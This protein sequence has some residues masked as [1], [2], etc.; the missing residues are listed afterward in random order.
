MPNLKFKT[1]LYKNKSNLNNGDIGFAQFDETKTEGTIIVKYADEIFDLMPAPGT[2]ATK[3]KPLISTGENTSPEYK[4]LPIEGGGTGATTAP[5]AL[6]N[7]G[8]DIS[9]EELNSIPDEF[10]GRAL[11]TEGTFFVQGSGSSIDST[12]KIATWKGTSNRFSSYY[13]GLSILYKLDVAGSS[14]V[15]LDI[16]GLGAKTVYLVNTTKLTTHFP[17]KSIIRL[18]YH[19]DLNSGCWMCNNYDSNT[20]TQ[21]RVYRQTSGYDSDYPLIASRTKASSIGEVDSNDSYTAVYGVMGNDTT[22]V[23]TLNPITGEI[24]AVKFTGPLNGT[25]DNA[26]DADHAMEAD[27]AQKAIYDKN[28]NDI[29]AYYLPIASLKNVNL[30]QGYGTCAISGS[31]GTV[32]LVNYVLLE[33]GIVSIKFNN[34]VAA[35]TTLNINNAGTRS[36]YYMGAQIKSNIIKKDDVATFIYS[37]QKY[38]LISIDR[39]QDDINSIVADIETLA[40]SVDQYYEDLEEKKVDRDDVISVE[41]GGTGATT[42]P[43]A[44]KS[45]GLTATATELNILDGITASTTELNYVDGV[46]SNIQTQL[47]SKQKTINGAA[48]TITNNNLTVSRALISNSSGKVAVSDITSTELGYLDGVTS[49]I[50]PQLNGKEPTI[51]TLPIAKGGTGATTAAAARANLGAASITFITWG[52]DD[53]YATIDG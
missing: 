52:E 4:T 5:D 45:L 20:N 2:A 10:A 32:T 35:N 34:D 33:G 24:K 31:T 50:Q 11:K 43:D 1:G 49:K 44:L 53:T 17:V 14:T 12:N 23:P 3:D 40:E 16:N 51:T 18:T 22:K 36:I 9:A 8:L 27:V 13:D 46:T 26:I 7:L 21:I 37:N 6:K 15:K 29:S 38:H 41:R 19:K 30:G 47:N 28:D 42:A 48:S 25:A 39:L